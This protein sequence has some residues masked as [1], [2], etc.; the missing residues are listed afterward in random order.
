MRLR[1]ATF[2][3]E[4][5]FARFRFAARVDPRRAEHEGFTIDDLAFGIHDAGQ[6][7]LTAGVIAATGADVVAL[8]EVEGLDALGAPEGH[9]VAALL[10]LGHPTRTFTKLTRAPVASFTTVDRVDGAPFGA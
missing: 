4:N 6:K 7:H 10:A 9:A 3:A 2:N 5:L 1:I 8:Q